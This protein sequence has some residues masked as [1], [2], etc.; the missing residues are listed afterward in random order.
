MNKIFRILPFFAVLLFASCTKEEIT[1][2]APVAPTNV[3][4]EYRVYAASALADVYAMLPVAGS[5][6]L[7]E[8]HTSINRM[9]YSLKFDVAVNTEV[10]VSAKNTNPGPEEVI[11]EIYVNDQLVKSGS[12]NGPGQIA[13]A[14]VIAK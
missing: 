12:A 9:N 1:P 11:V 14:T 8:E 3:H 13:T 6:T 10:S 2:T 5:S 7:V 4:V